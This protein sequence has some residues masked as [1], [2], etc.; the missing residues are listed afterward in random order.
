MIYSLLA[1]ETAPRQMT[2]RGK[3]RGGGRGSL[4]DRNSKKPGG[5]PGRIPQGRGKTHFS[6]NLK[7]YFQADTNTKKRILE[8]TPMCK[9]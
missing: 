9:Q 6:H 1:V 5:G 4:T 2:V 7:M 8:H 3:G